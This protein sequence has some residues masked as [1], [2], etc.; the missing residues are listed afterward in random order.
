MTDL[1]KATFGMG[2]F[3]CTE[4][5]FLILPGVTKVTSGY[6]GGTTEHP[7]YDQVSTGTTGHAEVIKVEYDAEKLSFE[8]LLDL[9]F[10]AHDATTLNRQGNDIG[11][12]YRS[13]ILYTNEVQRKKLQDYINKLKQQG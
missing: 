4:A 11:T 9:F 8:K 5:A 6:S 2:C 13:I 10:K 12:Q 1:K 7:N 3:W